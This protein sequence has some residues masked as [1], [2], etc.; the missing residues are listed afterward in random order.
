MENNKP[1]T[2]EQI[3][4]MTEAEIDSMFERFTDNI[5]VGDSSEMLPRDIG[6]PPISERAKKRMEAY[7]WQ[8]GAEKNSTQGENAKSD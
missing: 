4:L 2:D 8:Y 7:F 6:F 5:T 1:L 3:A